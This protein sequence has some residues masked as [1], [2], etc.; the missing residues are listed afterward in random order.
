[1]K[2]G[3]ESIFGKFILLNLL[4]SNLIAQQDICEYFFCSTVHKIKGYPAVFRKGVWKPLG[5]FPLIVAV[6]SLEQLCPFGFVNSA[7]H[8]LTQTYD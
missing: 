3:T 7:S 5:I 6:E 8:S 1:M 2:R 4:S